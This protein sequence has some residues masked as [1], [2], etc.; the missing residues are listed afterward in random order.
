MKKLLS[1][2][3]MAL[4]AVLALAGCDKKPANEGGGASSQ[5][6][7]STAPADSASSPM[8]PASPSQP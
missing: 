8:R 7:T 4:V 2:T 3:I 5:G 6:T 1:S